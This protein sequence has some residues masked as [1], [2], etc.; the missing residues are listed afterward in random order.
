MNQPE[1]RQ[2]VILKVACIA[3]L[4]LSGWSLWKY[5]L[6][7]LQVGFASEQTRRMNGASGVQVHDGP[8]GVRGL[9]ANKRK[10][11]HHQSVTTTKDHLNLPLCPSAGR[12]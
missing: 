10:D 2:P 11:A 5:G 9:G 6:L 1:Q 7:S 12:L 3:L 8:L 4:D